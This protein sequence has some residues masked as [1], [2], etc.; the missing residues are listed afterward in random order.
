METAGIR[1]RDRESQAMVQPVAEAGQHWDLE[2]LRCRD[3]VKRNTQETGS[4]V[5]E[6][7]AAG[8]QTHHGGGMVRPTG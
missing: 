3:A 1:Q 6:I 5:R 2:C 7:V 8:L 4:E